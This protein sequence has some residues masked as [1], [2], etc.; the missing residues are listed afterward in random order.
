MNAGAL[1]F[2][3]AGMGFAFVDC[4]CGCVGALAAGV[5]ISNLN[6]DAMLAGSQET[7]AHSIVVMRGISAKVT[8][9]LRREFG[10]V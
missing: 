6:D 8:D 3:M 2:D 1:L 5:G 4:D 7:S 9:I 10:T